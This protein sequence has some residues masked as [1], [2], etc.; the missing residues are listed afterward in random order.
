[1]IFGCIGTAYTPKNHHPLRATQNGSSGEIADA[2]GTTHL[3]EGD[4]PC[5]IGKAIEF[6]LP[7][8]IQQTFFLHQIHHCFPENLINALSLAGKPFVGFSIS[9]KLLNAGEGIAAESANLSQ[10]TCHITRAFT[11]YDIGCPTNFEQVI[12]GKIGKTSFL[13]SFGRY[14]TRHLSMKR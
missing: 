2:I 13:L 10:Q 1:M 12:I 11:G 7:I 8:L 9:R 14:V 5:A 3:L 4:R 6:D